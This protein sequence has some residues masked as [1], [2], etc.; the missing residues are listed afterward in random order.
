M[1]LI[2]QSFFILDIDVP[3]TDNQG[4]SEKLDG[5]IKKYEKRFLE[6]LLGASV[7]VD[8]MAGLELDPIPEKWQDLKNKLVDSDLKQSPIANYIYKFFMYSNS[9]PAVG[10]GV[11]I[12]KAENSIIISP[13]DKV[14]YAWNEMAEF[15]IDSR[16]WF[17]K[18]YA[19][20]SL[21]GY[22]YIAYYHCR[23]KNEFAP[24]NTL[25]F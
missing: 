19:D 21:T 2:D 12:P 17:N 25:N 22:Y 3:N 16:E 15:V 24:D 13:I 8:F 18:F 23:Y 11:S 14:V 20:N 5:F 6:L 7:Y 9:F 4:I 1:Q 10:L